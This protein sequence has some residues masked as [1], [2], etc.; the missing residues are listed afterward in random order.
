MLPDITS[1]KVYLPAFV[2]ILLRLFVR[3]DKYSMT[4][5]FG[6]AYFISLRVLTNLTVSKT[7]VLLPSA[8][9]FIMPSMG[10]IYYDTGI[11]MLVIAFSRMIL[12]S[13]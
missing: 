12:T 6:I 2:Y 8:V 11:F 13:D 9:F 4:F 3:L 1:Q 10:S 7:D 5:L